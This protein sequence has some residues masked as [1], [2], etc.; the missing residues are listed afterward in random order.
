MEVDNAMTCQ[1]QRMG[2]FSELSYISINDSYK[3]P[4]RE[5]NEDAAKGLQMVMPRLKTKS[6]LGDAYFDHEFKRVFVGE[7]YMPPSRLNR[8]YRLATM[9]KRI[10]KIPYLPAS[11][12]PLMVG[13]GTHYGTFTK[14]LEHMS[15]VEKPKKPFVSPGI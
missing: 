6:G 4:S 12:T 5:F 15:P 7:A 9:R 13:L 14:N 10:S 8:L 11:N 3:V 2:I 1:Q